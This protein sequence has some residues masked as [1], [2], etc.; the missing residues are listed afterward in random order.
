MAAIQALFL[1]LTCCAFRHGSS[2]VLPSFNISNVI[3]SFAVLQRNK[4][5]VVW[6]WAISPGYRISAE[7]VDGKTYDGFSDSSSLWRINF[8]AKPAMTTPFNVSLVSSAGDSIVL[9]ELLIGDVI[10]C[11]GQS[12]MGAV[13]VG[14]MA[15]ASEI[16]Q[17]AAG[18]ELLRIF[19]VLE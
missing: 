18:L 1:A 15:N 6:G 7:W 17:Q 3:G 2:T 10:F 11:S 13:Q 19:Q 12:N 14:V 8:P 16:V 9:S 5:V 4:P